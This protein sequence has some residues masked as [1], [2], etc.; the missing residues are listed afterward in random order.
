MVRW[1]VFLNPTHKLSAYVYIWASCSRARAISEQVRSNFHV[2]HTK[3][4]QIHGHTFTHDLVWFIPRSYRQTALESFWFVVA[5]WQM[6][7][8]LYSSVIIPGRQSYSGRIFHGKSQL[9][10][11]RKHSHS[12]TA[13]RMLDRDLRRQ[14]RDSCVA[15]TAGIGPGRRQSTIIYS[16][17]QWPP[18]PFGSSQSPP[19]I[20]DAKRFLLDTP[21]PPPT[22]QSSHRC[23]PG[24]SVNQSFSLL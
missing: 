5:P 4:T 6:A 12:K 1:N 14:V 17:A 24:K 16:A 8:I 10:T 7:K 2:S 11:P 21:P 18:A 20:M 15:T 19:S 22:L 3:F 23:A 13:R 9:T